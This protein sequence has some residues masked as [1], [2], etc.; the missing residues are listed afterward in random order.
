MNSCLSKG[1][2][3][4]SP[5][6]AQYPVLSL[7]WFSLFLLGN[8][9]LDRQFPLASKLCPHTTSLASVSL[10]EPQF[11]VPLGRSLAM[12]AAFTRR[13]SFLSST[14][15]R[16][17]LFPC[18]LRV[19]GENPAPEASAPPDS[20]ERYSRE[21]ATEGESGEW[22]IAKTQSPAPSQVPP[23]EDSTLPPNSHA[24]RPP[25]YSVVET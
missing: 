19:L 1:D 6:P 4:P 10:S 17:G 3:Y 8:Y 7:V 13:W 12:A 15:F 20:A 2:R 18:F 9:A 21:E 16:S 23:P 22:Q 25:R 24:S 14:F 11:N 5:T